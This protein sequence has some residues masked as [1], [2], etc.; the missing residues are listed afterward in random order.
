MAIVDYC[1][2]LYRYCMS[3]AL[4]NVLPYKYTKESIAQMCYFYSLFE[5]HHSIKNYVS[6]YG[7]QN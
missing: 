1:V 6:P 3:A 2:L 7:I 4:V 5:Q